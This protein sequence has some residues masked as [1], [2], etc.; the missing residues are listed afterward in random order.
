MIHLAEA[1]KT[2]QEVGP[3]YTCSRQQGHTSRMAGDTMSE[4]RN[5]GGMAGGE[6][7]QDPRKFGDGSRKDTGVGFILAAW[8]HWGLSPIVEK[9]HVWPGWGGHIQ[10]ETRSPQL[11]PEPPMPCSAVLTAASPRR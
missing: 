2:W 1:Y 10:K 6:E 3:C 4:P 5:A 9:C 7:P 11:H 8:G